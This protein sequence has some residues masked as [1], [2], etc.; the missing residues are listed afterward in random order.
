METH[1]RDTTSAYNRIQG[2]K[3][4]CRLKFSPDHLLVLVQSLLSH[5]L[6][7]GRILQL[8][9][10]GD[11]EGQWGRVQDVHPDFGLRRVL[12]IVALWHHLVMEKCIVLSISLH[13]SNF[14]V[15]N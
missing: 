8:Q 14:F 12:P 4:K 3:L 9:L 6:D 2:Y 1:P 13:F 5:K 7:E 10:P 15:L 11:R